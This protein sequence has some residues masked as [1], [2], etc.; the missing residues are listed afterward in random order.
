[1]TSSLR[2][3]QREG[4]SR[5]YPESTTENWVIDRVPSPTDDAPAERMHGRPVQWMIPARSALATS[6]GLF[7]QRIFRSAEW[8]CFT[9]VASA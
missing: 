3:K 9:T 2:Q 7:P 5:A 8:M 1:R 6:C 4:F